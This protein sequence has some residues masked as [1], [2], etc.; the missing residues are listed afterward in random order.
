[1]PTTWSTYP[2]EFKGGLI[3][4]MSPLQ[5]GINAPG[6][7]RT[8]KNFEPSIEGGYRRILGFTKFDSNIVPPYGNPVVHGASQSSTTLI[9]AAI[10]K[11]PEAGDTFTIAGVTGTY[12]IASG[13]VS[14]DDTNNRATLTLTGAL[15]SS[16]ANGALV[17]FA[18][19]TTSHLINGVT[20]WE[21]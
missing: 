3:T 9:I 6:S 8:L 12:T 18:T 5:Q 16:P 11:T 4:N 10:H 2:I 15:A 17:T 20:S 19:T 7:A 14:F 21:D 1:M 13:G